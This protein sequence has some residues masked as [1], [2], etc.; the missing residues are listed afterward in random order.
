[1]NSMD[2][3]IAN[4]DTYSIE[5][6][7]VLIS[8][9]EGGEYN[10]LNTGAYGKT[11]DN[12]LFTTVGFVKNWYELSTPDGQAGD[13]NFDIKPIS[14]SLENKDQYLLAIY[15]DE[16]H[17]Q[18]NDMFLAYPEQV[19]LIPHLS[20]GSDEYFLDK[21]RLNNFINAMELD[22]F[23]NK[24]DSTSLTKRWVG[25]KILVNQIETHGDE[26]AKLIDPSFNSNFLKFLLEECTRIEE[27]RDSLKCDWYDQKLFAIKKLAAE[28]QSSLK[29]GTER[30]ITFNDNSI[31]M[32]TTVGDNNEAYFES[33]KLATA[34]NYGNV[35]QKFAFKILDSSNVLSTNYY[36]YWVAVLHPNDLDSGDKVKEVFNHVDVIITSSLDLKDTHKKLKH[37]NSSKYATS[38]SIVLMDN[39]EFENLLQLVVVGPLVKLPDTTNLNEHESL[40]IELEEYCKFDRSVIN[41]I[42][43]NKE[44]M[45][46]FQ[47]LSIVNEYVMKVAN[48][49]VY[50][51][52]EKVDEWI[53][54]SKHL[55]ETLSNSE[56]LKNNLNELSNLANNNYSLPTE[57]KIRKG[58][59][60]EKVY[61]LSKTDIY[62]TY[63]ITLATYYKQLCRKTVSSFFEQLDI[64]NL[65]D[66]VWD[67]EHNKEIFIKYILIRGNEITGSKVTS[68]DNSAQTEF[69][70]LITKIIRVGLKNSKFRFLINNLM[71]NTIISGT[72][73]TLNSSL[74]QKR[75]KFNDSFNDEAV[76]SRTLN[77]FL[78]PEV[79]KRFT[80]EWNELIH[81]LTKHRFKIIY[82]L[83]NILLENKTVLFRWSF[84]QN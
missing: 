48:N 38:K 46:T 44:S 5:E 40:V 54:E 81:S 56:I 59:L 3:F 6:F 28:S 80:K 14:N 32:A 68:T 42:F 65:L 36:N 22:K 9:F 62:G 73:N 17:P 41:E 61:N 10:G 66:V 58:E 76:A 7:D 60:Y 18:R 30:T 15:Y 47:K 16:K 67:S 11:Q 82:F 20:K 79:I 13:S 37:S 2:E 23:P 31:T 4:I 75:R 77:F 29:Y 27:K 35:K 33:F 39:E 71:N 21:T 1:M 52:E 70:N 49:Q 51:N 74:K 12:N 25:M 26:L 8:L 64:E 55:F 24:K 83:I 53:N 43:K 72:L 84:S 63:L 78:L 50:K 45:T 57:N 34:L 69:L 19:T